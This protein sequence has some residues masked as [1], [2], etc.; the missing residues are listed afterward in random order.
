M[1]TSYVSPGVRNAP[2]MTIARA[3]ETVCY[4]RETG[5]FTWRIN[6]PK[7]VAGT[8]AGSIDHEGYVLIG[9]DGRRYRAHRLAIFMMTG[10]WPDNVVDHINGNP[11][12]NRASNLRESSVCQ[13]VRNRRPKSGRDLKGV[14]WADHANKWAAHICVDYKQKHL[15]YFDDPEDAARAYDA[16]AVKYHGEF[17]RLNFPSQQ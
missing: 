16:A 14:H 12:D 3:N 17:A 13:N 4:D 10:S 7:K 8:E 1:T 2:E 15:G 9:I 11:S 6:G 5:K